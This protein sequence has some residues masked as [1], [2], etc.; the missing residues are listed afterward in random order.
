MTDSVLDGAVF[1]KLMG[2]FATGVTV[3]TA[4]AADGHLQGMTANS[5]TSVSL[6]PPLILVCIDHRA[7]MYDTLTRG[8]RFAV[9]I[10]EASQETLSRRFAGDHDDRF[11]GIGY[12]ESPR[13]LILLDGALAHLECEREALHEAG[14]HTIVV[15]RVLAGTAAE[16]HPL[17]YFRGGYAA[18]A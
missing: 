8:Q 5:L 13:G 11:D 15:A 16:G 3:I 9:N 2:R 17:C 7:S 12:R 1:R 4:R 10:L 6:A 14:D 18:L